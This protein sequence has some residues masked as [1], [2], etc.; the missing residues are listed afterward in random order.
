[1]KTHHFFTLAG[2]L[3]VLFLALIC[4]GG[5]ASSRAAVVWGL[6]GF[7]ISLGLTAFIAHFAGDEQ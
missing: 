6:F 3:Q 5:L 2:L 4:F 7:V 1:M